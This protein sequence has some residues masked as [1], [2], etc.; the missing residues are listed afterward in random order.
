MTWLKMLV[1]AALIGLTASMPTPA[2][3][4]PAPLDDPGSGA[5]DGPDDPRCIS[6]PFEPQCQGGPYAQ[7][8]S[9]GDPSC[10]TVPTNPICAGGPYAIP[11]APPPPPA[12]PPAAP[13]IPLAPTIPAPPMAGGMP[14]HI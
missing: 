12:P 6:M 9:P 14:G 7:P 13:A 4:T 1:V 5:P 11:S 8:T 2:W 3:A 10:V